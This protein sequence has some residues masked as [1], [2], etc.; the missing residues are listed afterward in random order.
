MSCCQWPCRRKS[1][2]AEAVANIIRD[3]QRD[4]HETDQCTADRIGVSIGTV[5]N[6]RD[7]KDRRLTH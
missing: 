5:R 7:E 6:A 1:P 3:I 2:C 4:A